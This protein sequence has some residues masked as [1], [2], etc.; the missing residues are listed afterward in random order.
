M[1]R[2]LLI[3]GCLFSACYALDITPTTKSP[4]DEKKGHVNVVTPPINIPPPAPLPTLQP[5]ETVFY[6]HPGIVINQGGHWIGTDHLLNISNHIDIVVEILKP[7]DANPPITEAEIEKLI[8]DAF[9]KHEITSN[10]VSEGGTNQLPFFNLL[11][12]VYPVESGYAALLDGRLFESIDPKRVKLDEQTQFQAITWEKK[13]LIVAPGTDFKTIVENTVLD[14]VGTFLERYD[15]FDKLKL[16][17][18]VK[19]ETERVR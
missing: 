6:A 4:F 18:Q 11:L 9:K 16:K 12:V 8:Q 19:D 10:T 1:L 13:T 7:K 14:I 5:G 2:T 3:S 17:M 15:Y